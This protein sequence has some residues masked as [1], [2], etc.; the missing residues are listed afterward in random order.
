MLGA[1]HVVDYND[2]KVAEQIVAV[3]G[4]STPI[5]HAVD[6]V[7]TERS[8]KEL[9]KIVTEPGSRVALLIPFKIGNDTDKHINEGGASRLLHQ[10][11]PEHNP[12]EVGVDTVPTY[13]FTWETNPALGANLLTS[14]FPEFLRLGKIKSQPVRLLKSGTVLERVQEAATRLKNNQL[15]GEKAIVLIQD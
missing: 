6:T 13:T 2:P 3:T 12:F 11:P 10:L 9:S 5:K 14:I 1:T 15:G 8:M 7:C 4:S